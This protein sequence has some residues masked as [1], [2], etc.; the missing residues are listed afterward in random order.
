[1]TDLILMAQIAADAGTWESRVIWE[2]PWEP[3]VERS[4]AAELSSNAASSAAARCRELQCP[5]EACAW[6]A[7][8]DM[9]ASRKI[10]MDEAMG[11]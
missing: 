2:S 3:T 6:E 10:A 9:W 11:V 5:A 1:M 4:Q 8:S 7:E